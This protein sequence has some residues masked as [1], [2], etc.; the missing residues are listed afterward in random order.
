MYRVANEN[1]KPALVSLWKRV[2]G[3]DEAYSLQALE[4]FAGEGNVYVAEEAGQPAAMLLAVPC[5]IEE[6]SGIY[7]YA[8]ATEPKQRGTGIMAGLMA[9]SEEAAV[10]KGACFSVLIPATASLYRYYLPKGYT[11]F[12]GLRLVSVSFKSDN[13]SLAQTVVITPVTGQRLDEMR[14]EYLPEP[15]VRFGSPRIALIAEDLTDSGAVM[16]ISYGEGYAVGLVQGGRLL[17]PELAA[18]DD[19]SALALAAS[20]GTYYGFSKGE[21][22]LGT[23]SRLLAGKGEIKPT[24]LLK[25]LSGGFCPKENLYLRFAM[26]D[27]SSIYFQEKVEGYPPPD[28]G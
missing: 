6:A 11:V 23:A 1:D 3:D 15:W 7:L 12:A 8:L 24:G 9:Y 26:D 2:F 21:I 10:A 25:S 27:A 19:A 14:N 16:A 17:V 20:L 22:S 4:R 5:R 18:K 13:S 28:N